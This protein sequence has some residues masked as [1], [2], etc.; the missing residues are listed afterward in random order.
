M[1]KRNIRFFVV[2]LLISSC[3]SSSYGWNDQNSFAQS[4]I[5]G[6]CVVGAAVGAAAVVDWCFSETDDQLI[7]RFDRECCDADSQYKDLMG[8]VE[9]SYRIYA[10]PVDSVTLFRNYS[11]VTLYELATAVIN[12]G[13]S[14]YTYRSNVMAV[15]KTLQS[16]MNILRKRIYTLERKNCSPDELRRLQSMRSLFRNAEKL[17]YHIVF[18]AGY[19]EHHK[20]YCNLYDTVTTVRNNYAHCFAIIEQELYPEINLKN[21]IVYA[22]GGRYPFITFVKTIKSDISH[23]RSNIN[24]LAY[25]YETGR[26][27]A[28]ITLNQLMWMKDVVMAD[29]RYAQECFQREQERLQ[30][31]QLQLMEAQARAEFD[32]VNALCEQNRLLR[33]RNY[34]EKQKIGNKSSG[35]DVTVVVNI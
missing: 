11:E 20:S 21:S 22:I 9:K 6:I 15:K 10:F 27:Y 14:L 24:S 16:S 2:P 18:F 8:Y 4:L 23:L 33:Q 26:R 25:N 31:L 13:T 5:T 12:S 28:T 3:F 32:R 29:A 30:Q 7:S 35:C 19:L 1:Y 34:L 17:I